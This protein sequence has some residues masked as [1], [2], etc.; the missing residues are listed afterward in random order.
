[1]QESS[2]T[3]VRDAEHPA[4]LD[5]S[6]ARERVSRAEEVSAT[7]LASAHEE[8]EGFVWRV[9]HLLGEL[10]QAHQAREMVVEN[11]RGLSDAAVNAMQRQDKSKREF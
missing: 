11:C 8:V 7:A 9:A 1:M 3:L 2:M 4:S 6:E 5:E 10:V